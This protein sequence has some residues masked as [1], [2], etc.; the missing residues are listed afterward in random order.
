MMKSIILGLCLAILGI[1]PCLA[2]PVGQDIKG[3]VERFD[4]KALQEQETKDAVPASAATASDPDQLYLADRKEQWAFK[5][6]ALLALSG[7][8]VTLY[9]FAAVMLFRLTNDR[10]RGQNLVQLTSL[11]LIV[12]G[13]LLLTFVSADTETLTAPIGILGALAGY[14]F[15]H[16]TS[17][18]EDSGR[19]GSD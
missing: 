16:A 1:S 14:L 12:F 13:T 6:T 19:H 2:A 7:T 3:E 9:L 15:G 10:H 18:P 5:R 8:T 4:F 11:S 17:R